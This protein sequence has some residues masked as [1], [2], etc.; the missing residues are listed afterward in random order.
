MQ[1]VP[2]TMFVDRFSRF[3][4]SSDL[5][6]AVE[7]RLRLY[8]SHEDEMNAYG[9]SMDGHPI[10]SALTLCAYFTASTPQ[11]FR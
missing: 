8:S 1:T 7:R 2:I 10:A 11:F 9:A 4:S 6:V 3:S 5:F